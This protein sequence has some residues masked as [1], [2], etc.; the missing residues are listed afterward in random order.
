MESN[1]VKVDKLLRDAAELGESASAL[2]VSIYLAGRLAAN[3]DDDA[4]TAKGVS[5]WFERNS[6]P[7]KW[8]LR[9]ASIPKRKLDLSLYA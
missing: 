8:M 4:I 1:K 2:S 9:V 6:I 5:K 3:H 7:S